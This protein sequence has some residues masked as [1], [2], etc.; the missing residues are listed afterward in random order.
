MVD[1]FE[2]PLKELVHLAKRATCSTANI[3]S[4]RPGKGFGAFWHRSF[5]GQLS[6]RIHAG[7][8]RQNL[9]NL[10]SSSRSISKTHAR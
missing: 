9:F 7:R 1:F 8:E 3:K 5:T 2:N 10:T 4:G 6:A